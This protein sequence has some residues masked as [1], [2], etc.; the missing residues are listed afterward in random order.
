[1]D[2]AVH[3]TCRAKVDPAGLLFFLCRF[4]YNLH[5]LVDT[6]FFCGGNGHYGYPQPLGQE[7]YI[8]RAVVSQ[9][10][11]HHIES[12]HHRLTHLDKL[13]RQVQIA[14]DI[15]SIGDVDYGVGF[16]VDDKIAR[17]LLLAGIGT[18]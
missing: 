14:L 11:I 13:K 12:Q 1:M 2:A 7:F 16:F 5:K 6:V 3:G 17:Y 9:K 18:D 10:L 15:C 4:R 8:N